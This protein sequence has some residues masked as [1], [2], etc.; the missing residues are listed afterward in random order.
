MLAGIL[1]RR[2]TASHRCSTRLRAL[3]LSPP[4]KWI[5]LPPFPKDMKKQENTRCGI[6]LSQSKSVPTAALSTSGIR[7]EGGSFLSACPNKLPCI[8]SCKN[9]T[10]GTRPDASCKQSLCMT[11]YGGIIRIRLKGRRW[12][13]PLSPSSR[14]PLFLF[15]GIVLLFFGF[16]KLY[17]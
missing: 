3:P 10:G 5:L 2:N 9:K 8:F 16:C 1:S 12:F 7:V 17:F 14:T 6:L 15:D 11:S 13:L 4:R